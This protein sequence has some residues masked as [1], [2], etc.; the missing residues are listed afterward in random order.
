L[1]A[2]HDHDKRSAKRVLKHLV[3]G[4]PDREANCWKETPLQILRS[5]GVQT[6]LR[7]YLEEVEERLVPLLDSSYRP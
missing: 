3:H 4:D 5:R 1:T 2:I 6:G 7:E